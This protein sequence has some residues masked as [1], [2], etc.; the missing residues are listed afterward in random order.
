VNNQLQKEKKSQVVKNFKKK[1][2]KFH[3]PQ[4]SEE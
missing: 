1:A 2:D 4:N 3:K